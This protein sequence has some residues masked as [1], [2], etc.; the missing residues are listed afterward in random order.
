MPAQMVL[1]ILDGR[2]AQ[3]WP[4]CF[5][6]TVA[7]LT[8]EETRVFAFSIIFA[9]GIGTG[10]L[11]GLAGGYIP[12]ALPFGEPPRLACHG[13]RFVLIG[14]SLLAMLG[15]LAGFETED[16]NS[17][18]RER[19]AFSSSIHF[20][21]A[22]CPHSL[23]WSIVTGSFI[24]F[25]PV[26]FQKQL[27]IP[28]QHVG[29]I[30]S[31]SEFVQFCAVLLVPFLYQKIGAA[32]G[33]PHRTIGHRCGSIMLGSCPFSQY[34]VGWYLVLAGAQFTAGPGF[35]GMLMS[36]MPESDRSDAS[37]MQNMVGALSRAGASSPHRS[38]HRAVRIRHRVCA[39]CDPRAGFCCTRDGMPHASNRCVRRGSKLSSSSSLSEEIHA[40][41]SRLPDVDFDP[42]PFSSTASVSSSIPRSCCFASPYR[43]SPIRPAP[44]TP[45]AGVTSFGARLIPTRSAGRSRS[46]APT[47]IAAPINPVI[48]H[49]HNLQSPLPAQLNFNPE[50]QSSV[51]SPTSLVDSPTS[52]SLADHTNRVKSIVFKI[53]GEP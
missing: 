43:S 31:A 53:R 46:T 14:A 35:Y 37:A 10:T 51:P 23:V 30:F 5:A 34:A 39:G 21:C 28:L 9:T 24:P 52:L 50:P 19:Q 8:T 36:R 49:G 26:F 20:F 44:S 4:V 6:P 40:G 33:N 32:G 16:Q 48:H 45:S 2:G 12:D 7:R 25:A 42:S 22:F 38:P 29:M 15:A 27:G 17:P 13:M 47:S 11:A 18:P 41:P 3:R 1:R